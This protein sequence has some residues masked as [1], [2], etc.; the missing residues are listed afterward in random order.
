MFIVIQKKNGTFQK[1]R[2][3]KTEAAA[4]KLA[5]VL[6]DSAWLEKK[7]KKAA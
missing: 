4:I 7:E 5:D 6:K 1:V 2:E 3:F